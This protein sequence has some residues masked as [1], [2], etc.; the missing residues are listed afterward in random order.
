[1]KI[2]KKAL[3]FAAAVAA[4]GLISACAT[5]FPLGILYTKVTTPVALGANEL[6]YSK[7][8]E[9]KC[10]SLCGLIASGDASINAAC[11]P[12][13]ITKVSWVSYTVNNFCGI[14]GTYTT[15]VYGD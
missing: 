13:G 5:P 8:G 11:Q 3:I 2:Y 7:T 12:N 1:M 4:S 9:A 6:Q 14:Y 10:F 15:T